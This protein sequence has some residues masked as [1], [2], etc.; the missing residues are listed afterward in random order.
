MHAYAPRICFLFFLICFHSHTKQN[1]VECGI[2]IHRTCCSKVRGEKEKLFVRQ[3]LSKKILSL[4]AAL[5]NCADSKPVFPKLSPE[6]KRNKETEK[7]AN[8]VEERTKEI[9]RESET[10]PKE[11]RMVRKKK[12]PF[13]FFLTGL[14]E[15]IHWFNSSKNLG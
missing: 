8:Q 5:Q 10:S 11:E 12:N 15:N 3:Q 13:C 14:Q 9:L 7:V 1:F 2:I 6:L 4:Q